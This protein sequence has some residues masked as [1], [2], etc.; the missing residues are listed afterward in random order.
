MRTLFYRLGLTIST[1]G[2][3]IIL[4]ATVTVFEGGW[5]GIP[6][7][8]LGALIAWPASRLVEAYRPGRR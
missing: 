5:I 3:I 8:A 7:Y 2:G 1:I 4:I 6:L